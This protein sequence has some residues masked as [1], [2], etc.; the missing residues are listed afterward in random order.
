VKRL[1]ARVT[2]FLRASWPWPL[3]GA[4][5]LV[6]LLGWWLVPK[7]QVHGLHIADA[8]TRGDLEDGFRKTITQLLAGVAVLVGAGLAYLQFRQQQRTTREQN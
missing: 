4:L 1:M 2:G 3:I 8:K 7:W 6:A 5:V